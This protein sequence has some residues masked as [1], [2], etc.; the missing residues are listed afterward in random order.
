MEKLFRS[1]I[2][3]AALAAAVIAAGVW[4]FAPYV[5]KDVATSA[6]VNAELTRVATPVAGVLTEGLPQ[7]GAFLSKDAR[8]RLVTARTPNRARLDDLEQQ[9]ALAAST[10]DLMEAQLAE[11]GRDDATLKARSAVFK[12][13]SVGRLG[14]RV[15]QAE[16]EAAACEARR[17]ELQDKF[18]RA[19]RLAEQG[20]VSDAGLR[21]A[22]DAADA[23]TETC[24]AARANLVAIRVEGEAAQKGVFL[25]DGANDAPYA[26]QQRARLML[27]RQE[28]MTE[29]VKARASQAQ[30]TAQV[31]AERQ[32]Y[33]RATSYEAVLPAGHLVWTVEAR[34]GSE[35][36]EGQPL[37]TVADCRNR[38]VVVELPA[39][40]IERL[41]VGDAARVRLLGSDHWQTGRV[42]RITGGAARQD[43]RLFAAEMPRPGPRSFTVEVSLDETA[44]VDQRRSCDIG[45][46]A[47]VRF[48][49]PLMGG[50]D[51]RVAAADGPGRL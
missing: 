14:G 3:R 16:A 29:L 48:D 15:Q 30:L 43:M 5:L 40:K 39:R 45:R 28:L 35:V 20:F 10:V 4:G 24:K 22:K 51:R 41:G 26:E 49:G 46:S 34:P 6:Y 9:A 47:D 12:A 2:A 13:A 25:S 23:G 18:S 37:M 31:A 36:V 8:L 44:V 19:Q 7:E 27:R 21:S 11:L 50:P 42:R 32:L 33:A 17:R 38:F 1:R